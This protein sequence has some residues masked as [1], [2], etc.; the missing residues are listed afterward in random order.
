M[1]LIACQVTL[2]VFDINI[3]RNDNVVVEVDFSALAVQFLDQSA[4]VL[5]ADFSLIVD[6]LCCHRRRSSRCCCP[7]DRFLLVEEGKEVIQLTVKSKSVRKL[8]KY[9]LDLFFFKCVDLLRSVHVNVS[10]EVLVDI[11]IRVNISLGRS[12]N[13]LSSAAAGTTACFL[14]DKF[15]EELAVRST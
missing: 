6:L 3:N 15:K 9:V 8:T 4:K 10:D 2:S 12:K 14:R 5:V 7:R 11:D 1:E 13:N